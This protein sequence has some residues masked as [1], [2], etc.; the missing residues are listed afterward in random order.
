MT[1]FIDALRK[2]YIQENISL[3]KLEKMLNENKITNDEYDYIIK[4]EEEE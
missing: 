1:G 3:E 4:K 2:L